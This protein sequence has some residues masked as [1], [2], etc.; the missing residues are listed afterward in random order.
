MKIVIATNNSNKVDEIDKI[1]RLNNLTDFILET[2]KSLGLDSNP[3]E[4]ADTLEG[5][6]L[7][8]SVSLF[9]LTQKSCIA[10]D[11][12]L[13]VRALDGKPG[14]H[15]ARFASDKA[16]DSENRKL[17]LQL[18]EN[19]ADRTAYFETVISYTDEI[20]QYYFRGRCEGTIATSEKGKNGFGYDSI[21]IPKGYNQTFAELDPNEKNIIS[22]RYKAI[23]E[24]SKWLKSH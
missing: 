23:I 14:V 3:D 9:K 21:F 12:G 17:L 10:D 1:L 13:F 5:N 11:T 16:N 20:E 6:A 7:I 8:K 24:F 18:L 19:K 15:S 22:H 2:P 4:N